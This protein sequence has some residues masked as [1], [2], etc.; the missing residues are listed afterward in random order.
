MNRAAW[1]EVDLEAIR[2]NLKTIRKLIG[3]EVK[4][5]S[6][7]KADAYGH[8]AEQVAETAV[9]CGAKYLGVATVDEAARLARLNLPAKIMILSQP[10]VEAIP[11]ILDF[12]LV[13]TV[14]T[15]QF[16]LALGEAA[17]ARGQIAD[18]QLKIDT[19]FNRI[20]VPWSD[21]AA[22][23]HS[24]DFHRALH[25]DGVFTHFATADE[26]DTS[27]V[28]LQLQ[29]F[30]EAIET[31]R[32]MGIKPGL[33]HA[34]NS[35][36]TIRF[37]ETHFDMVRVG[38]AQ[39]GL[40]PSPV[41]Q[42]LATL[43]PAMSV[44]ARIVRIEEVPFGEGVSYNWTYQSPGNVE[45]FTL[46]I[47]YAD[48]LRRALSNNFSVSIDGLAYRSAGNI[49]MDMSMYEHQ[50]RPLYGTAPVE[51]KIGDEAVFPPMDEL[52]ATL[53]TISYELCCGFGARLEKV[54]KN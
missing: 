51:L 31:I 21:A 39:Y 2:D 15:Q 41:T 53:G 1:I 22:F 3:P 33:I 49:C 35:A 16:A 42:A 13:P 40:H 5:M 27:G 46:P 34:A 26:V 7:V 20:G 19:G 43:K 44:H 28:L 48:G 54:Y 38:L 45:V 17:D 29:R 37:R 47:G 23:L 25:L 52:A 11:Q 9:H 32:Y 10:D 12:H 14:F 18:Y 36:A 6:V 24:I 50:L 4:I 30:N 8:G